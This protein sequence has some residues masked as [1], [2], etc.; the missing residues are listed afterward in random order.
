MNSELQFLPVLLYYHTTVLS[1]SSVWINPNNQRKVVSKKVVLWKRVLT[2]LV[3]GYVYM[4]AYDN[5]I[6]N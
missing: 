4:E 3:T 6:V 5:V 1:H 2:S